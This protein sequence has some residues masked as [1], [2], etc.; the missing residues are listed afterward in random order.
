M[1]Y[2]GQEGHKR[3]TGHNGLL[4]YWVVLGCSWYIRD[5]TALF[6]PFF[7]L[8]QI[9]SGYVVGL[10]DAG[11][12]GAD[13]SS[14]KYEKRACKT[15]SARRGRV[16]FTTAATAAAGGGRRPW[17]EQ[18]WVSSTGIL[19]PVLSRN[20]GGR[21]SGYF[22]KET[23]CAIGTPVRSKYMFLYRANWEICRFWQFVPGRGRYAINR[24]LLFPAGG[25]GLNDIF[26]VDWVCRKLYKWVMNSFIY[27]DYTYKYSLLFLIVQIGGLCGW[28]GEWYIVR[29][30]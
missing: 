30:E 20:D 8:F 5:W 11:G 23:H 19:H 9:R 7:V 10:A 3:D 26:I 13:C 18:M 29:S 1:G 21:T 2:H 27:D 24:R 22:R 15:A 17:K 16:R 25:W 6:I 4:L 12:S 14:S 28:V